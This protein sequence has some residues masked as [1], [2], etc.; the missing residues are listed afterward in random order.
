MTSAVASTCKKIFER[1][2]FAV[3]VGLSFGLSGLGDIIEQ[4][5]EK[6]QNQL[7][8]PQLNWTRTLHMSTSFGLTSGFL[9]HFWYNYLDK[10]LPGRGVRVVVQKIVFDQILFSP[11]CIT[12]CLLVA[13]K[14]EN[15]TASNLV[16]QT[17][18]LGGRLYLAEWVIWPPAQFINF[19]FLPTRFRV[20]YDNIISLVYDTYTSHIKYQVPVV[21]NFE[22]DLIKS[23]IVPSSEHFSAALDLD[24]DP[25]DSESDGKSD[26]KSKAVVEFQ[27]EEHE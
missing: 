1:H 20:L 16:S 8:K 23:G 4:R 26:T 12:A 2:L 22:E 15:K 11:V 3:N 25:A 9:C 5:L 10:V 21:D 17:I 24:N 14:L 7:K 18:Q 6:K 27:L 19:Y 13:G